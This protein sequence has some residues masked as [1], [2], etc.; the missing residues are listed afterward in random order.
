MLSGDGGIPFKLA[1]IRGISLVRVVSDEVA[2]WIALNLWVA[3]KV[4]DEEV[5]AGDGDGKRVVLGGGSLLPAFLERF[6][7]RGFL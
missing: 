4:D 5:L 2:F 1:L 7:V 3:S 6:D